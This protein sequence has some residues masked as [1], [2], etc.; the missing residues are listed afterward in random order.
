MPD[1]HF[2]SHSLNPNSCDTRN[3]NLK[4]SRCGPKVIASQIQMI[5]KPRNRPSPEKSTSL[6]RLHMEL[7]TLWKFGHRFLMPF[8]VDIHSL[9]LESHA[10]NH[11]LQVLHQQYMI[12]NFLE[13]F[14]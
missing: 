12:Q 13:D 8:L 14:A 6:V 2:V 10:Q 7:A 11:S 3:R 4:L 1:N 9:S 5:E